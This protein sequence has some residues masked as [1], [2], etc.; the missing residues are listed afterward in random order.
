MLRKW[1]AVL[2][3]DKYYNPNLSLAPGHDFELALRP[4]VD[5]RAFVAQARVRHDEASN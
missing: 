5:W 3:S 4:R 1:G 2:Q